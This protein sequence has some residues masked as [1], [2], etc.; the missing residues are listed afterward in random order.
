MR[1][2]SE[3][4]PLG[5]NYCLRAISNEYFASITGL[6]ESRTSIIICWALMLS[7]RIASQAEPN[8]P[9]Q[10]YPAR[11]ACRVAPLS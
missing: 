3:S 11:L 7:E 1:F 8:K 4:G 10:F 9:A 6:C 5:T 2:W